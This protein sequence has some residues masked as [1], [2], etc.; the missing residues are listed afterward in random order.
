MRTVTVA[1][2]PDNPKLAG[3]GLFLRLSCSH[4]VWL[5][6]RD[7]QPSQMLGRPQPCL[8][9]CYEPERYMGDQ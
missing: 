3:Y 1:T 4:S 5:A 9:G 6:G 2:V 7:M 8:S